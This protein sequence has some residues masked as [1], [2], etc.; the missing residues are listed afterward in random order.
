MYHPKVVEK[1]LNRVADYYRS[2]GLADFSFTD[3]TVPQIVEWTAHLES[4]YDQEEKELRRQLNAEEENFIREQLAR[5]KCDYR[6][7][8]ERFAKIKTKRQALELISFWESQKI[9]LERIAEL[10]WGCVIEHRGDGIVL[11]V[12]KAR[13]LG[14]ST[15]CESIL[16]HRVVFFSNTTA[17]VAGDIP[18]QS[19]YLFDMMERM[20][21]HLPWWMKPER[22]YH[23][24]DEQMY[25][26]K[27]DSLIL[28]GS[29]KSL[30][31]GGGS[32]GTG[33]TI[34]LFHGSELALWENAGQIDD[35]LMP[36]IPEHE[37]TFAVFESTAKGRIGWWPE[38]W[39]AA[40]KGI[41]RRKPVFI[42]WYA[43]ENTYTRRPPADW[44]PA[45]STLDH[46]R[47]VEAS[48]YR[49][50]GGR[51]VRLSVDQ[52]YWYEMTRADYKERRV[53]YKFLAEYCAS[54]EEAFQHTGDGVIPPELIDDIRNRAREHV[55]VID[56]IPRT[57]MRA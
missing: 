7:W 31:A 38:A 26:G 56:V 33:K 21:D 2:A 3:Y 4:L 28:V 5:C 18:D 25:F 50:C 46:A 30:R 34:H 43:E 49:W 22:D 23:V 12:L 52:M 6:W 1:R 29:S 32:L 9:L 48:S 35:A 47:R 53:L 8:A 41:G 16:T 14:A 10:E 45:E 55:A 44:K 36:S 54:P 15:V 51:T 17:L 42:P 57:E 24:K 27:Q 19:A 39:K 40:E 20:Y 37:R 13:Q 11:C